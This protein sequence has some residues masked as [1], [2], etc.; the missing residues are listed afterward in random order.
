MAKHSK[1]K[2]IESPP[3]EPNVPAIPDDIMSLLRDIANKEPEVVK[4]N[5]DAR[6]D[7]LI[8]CTNAL[9]NVADAIREISNHVNTAPTI[10][11]SYDQH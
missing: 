9:S 3:P 8:A 7:V 11:V 4:I 6:S 10:Q 1:Q 2:T 5:G